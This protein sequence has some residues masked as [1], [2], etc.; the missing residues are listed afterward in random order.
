MRGYCSHQRLFSARLHLNV[1]V[2]CLLIPADITFFFFFSFSGCIILY[3]ISIYFVLMPFLS[4]VEVTHRCK[5]LILHYFDEYHSCILHVST[6]I[7]L[8]FGVCIEHFAY[9]P[10]VFATLALKCWD[11]TLK[12]IIRGVNL[13]SFFWVAFKIVIGN[14]TF[15]DARTVTIMNVNLYYCL[16]FSVFF[17]A[18]CS[19]SR[20]KGEFLLVLLYCSNEH[21]ELHFLSFLT[22]T[23]FLLRTSPSVLFSCKKKERKENREGFVIIEVLFGL[24]FSLGRRAS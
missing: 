2:K 1:E 12:W 18:H 13:F 11:L 15:A 8:Y 19:A 4:S 17:H 24:E 6:L 5:L 21:D 10:F 9:L 23:F 14:S 22:S 16:I 20:G 7:R 3:Y